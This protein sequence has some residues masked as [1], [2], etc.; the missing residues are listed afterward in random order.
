MQWHIR[1]TAN[2]SDRA[3]GRFSNKKAS[4]AIQTRTLTHAAVPFLSLLSILFLSFSLFPSLSFSFFQQVKQRNSFSDRSFPR[5]SRSSFL[6]E[7]TLFLSVSAWCAYISLDN[8]TQL[9]EVQWGSNR[10]HHLHFI[11]ELGMTRVPDG[12]RATGSRVKPSLWNSTV[13]SDFCVTSAVFII[14]IEC[15]D[16]RC[17]VS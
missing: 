4:L 11:A 9:A 1:A 7:S 3:A 14:A 13:G 17:A 16:N 2:P 8:I 15:S 12:W 5:W 10:N 6:L